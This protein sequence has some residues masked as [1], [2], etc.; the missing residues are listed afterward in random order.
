M[1]AN[2]R[3][4]LS[5]QATLILWVG[6]SY[7]VDEWLRQ[8][9]FARIAYFALPAAAA[10]IVWLIPKDDSILAL[11]KFAKAWFNILSAYVAGIGTSV[12]LLLLIS[13]AV[14]YLPYSDRPGPGW[15]NI[16]RH[17]PGLDEIKYFSGWAFFFLLPTCYFLGSVLF[18]FMAWIRWLNTPTWLARAVG[19]LFGYGLTALAVA[20]AGWYIAISPFVGYAVAL[21]GLLFGIFV[22]PRFAP[23]REMHL[24]TG[25]RAVGIILALLGLTAFLVYPFVRSG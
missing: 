25:T 9:S 4:F 14:G 3:N 8:H 18:I 21:L 7:L 15:G 20:A 12:V 22:L 10:L 1:L 5:A 19:G 13:S 16:P 2:D 17:L 11:K 24:S 23:D 6:S